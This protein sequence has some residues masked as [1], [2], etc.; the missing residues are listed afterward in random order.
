MA[1][2]P[3]NANPARNEFFQQLKPCCVSI[4]QLAIRQQGDSSSFKRLSELTDELYHILNDQ[5]NRDAN[6]LDSKLADYV[7]FPLSHVFRS[8]DQYPKRLIELAI[9]CLTVII[10]HGWKSNISPQILQQLLILLTFIVGGVPGREREHNVPE[11]TE[12][13]SLRALTALLTVAGTSSTA[14]TALT[15]ERLVPTLGH[16]I[17]VILGCV[18]DG[19][20]SAIQ[21]EALR[22]LNCFYTSIKDHAA[23]ASF[24]P[25]IVSSLT[26]LLSKPQGEKTRVLVGSIQSLGLVLVKVLG[27]VRTR[28]IIARLNSDTPPEAEQGGVLSLSW[29]N[30]TKSQIKL[31]LATVLKLR[32]S[33]NT[34][35]REA[36][37][38]FCLGLLD[39]CHTSLENCS[40]VLVETAMVISPTHPTTSLTGTSLQDLAIIYP[41]LGET[42]KVTCYNWIT[43]LPRIM[44]SA[45]ESKKQAAVQNLM[46]GMALVSSLQLDS[47]LL[48]ESIAAA[49]RDSVTSLITGAKP[50]KILDETTPDAS[51]YNQDIVRIG[52]TP[53]QY[54]NVLLGEES[55][56]GTRSAMIDL[57]SNV[58]PASQQTRLAAEMLDHA[59]DSSGDSQIAS[60]WLS[61]E[62]LKTAFSRSNE[63]DDL[64]DFSSLGSGGECSES[65]FQELYAFAVVLLDSHSELAEIDWRLEATAL[66]VTAF[67]ASRSG[68]A[69][70]PELIDVLYPTTAFLGSASSQLREH[71]ITTLNVLA[72]SCG[73]TSVSEL[74]IENVDYMINSV[75]LRLNT[76]DISPAS[77]KVLVMITRLTGSRLLPYLDDVVAS[78]FAALD[79]YHGYPVFV[80]SLFAV[81]KEVVEQG[82]KSDRL[83]LE[84]RQNGPESHKKAAGSHV[85]IDDIV[86]LLKRRRERETE[87]LIDDVT[88]ETNNSHPQ[89]P[90]GAQDQKPKDGG[91]EGIDEDAANNQVEKEKPPK[92][93]TYTLLEKIAGLTQHYLTSPSPTL[94][95]S[96]LDLL[97][98]VSPAL[99]GDEDSF[100]PLINAVWPVV[101]TRIYDEEAFVTISAC[102]ALCA[103]SATAGDF[104]ASRIKTEWWDGLG[105]WC[106]KKKLEA[107]QSRGKGSTHRESTRPGQAAGT[108]SQRI[109][110]PVMTGSDRLSYQSAEITKG[111]V[112]GG[113]GKFAQ[114]AQIWDSV[115][116]MLTAIAS[117]VRLDA[118]I[119]DE[120]LDLLSEALSQNVEA[121]RALEAVNGDAVWL[122]MY[123][124]GQVKAP[125]LPRLNGVTF[126]SLTT[127]S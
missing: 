16:T 4:S 29:L 54:S 82:V 43:S 12:L 11:E 53:K 6:V 96:L 7:F 14:A 10:I 8:H 86:N 49:L 73:Y 41:E 83:L 109:V 105:K 27:D 1:T 107:I 58:G 17:T 103:L 51:W 60:F 127:L 121:R 71:A 21:L 23:L 77:T 95:K 66:E 42:V 24:I 13:E 88:D 63:L 65:T 91:E 45:D 99:S 15:E 9:K 124:Q 115:I 64:L 39:E 125:S 126:A 20:T 22:I 113:L 31:A 116:R 40:S 119:F 32:I 120:V 104:L 61:F 76:F 70:R 37:L 68:E 97:A 102:D 72:V 89:E 18:A 26:K 2:S 81:L 30:A 98:T 56:T 110:I 62:L 55:Q 47:S 94:R 44:Q 57:L 74:I 79:N 92:T 111:S 19:R 38:A 75:S 28:S 25:G 100:L 52:D 46:K 3:A 85:T 87:A 108:T 34:D 90:W 80:E 112:S 33:D 36:L 114:S 48:D 69:F 106:R 117:H 50:S 93:P 123:Q 78:I 67:A 118:E 59:R 5:V 84:G 35:V 122:A 101:I